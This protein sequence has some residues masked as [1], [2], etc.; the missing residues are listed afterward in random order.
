MR[1][2]LTRTLLGD[3][4]TMGQL[5]ID[6]RYCCDTLE[7]KDR[8]LRSDMSLEEIKS[9]KV[10]GKTAIPVGVYEV[11]ITSSPAFRMVLP[12]LYDVPGYS[13]VLIHAGNSVS[14]TKG[15]ILVGEASREDRLTN[16]RKALYNILG[17]LLAAQ[18]KNERIEIE[19]RWADGLSV[20]R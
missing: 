4:F 17:R 12:R 18:S 9:I 8:L 16:S 2:V 3:D 14:D 11:A 13:G 7:C 1:L 15:C 6:G 10:Y 20:G 5:S 19:I